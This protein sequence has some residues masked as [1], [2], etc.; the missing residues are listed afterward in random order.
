MVNRRAMAAYVAQPYPGRITLFRTQER[1]REGY[2][3][4]LLGWGRLAAG[5]LEIHDVP[6][7]HT[8]ML[9]EPHVAVTAGRLD[10]CL[11]RA[12]GERPT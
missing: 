10:E 3:D 1:A 6:G 2:H 9:E 5:G 4:P 12:R 11:R 7:S 8:T